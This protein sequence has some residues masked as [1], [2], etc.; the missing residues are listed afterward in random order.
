[1]EYAAVQLM[2]YEV[3]AVIHH[4]IYRIADGGYAGG[5]AAVDDIV[6]IAAKDD[7]VKKF[8]FDLLYETS[9]EAYQKGVSQNAKFEI[10]RIGF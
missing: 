9:L 1:M 5:Y 3:Y 10:L 4:L 2:A 8:A 6:R 7:K